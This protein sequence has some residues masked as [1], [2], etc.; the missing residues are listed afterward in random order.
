MSNQNQGFTSTVL[1]L[2]FMFHEYYKANPESE[3]LVM[4]QVARGQP[5][6][7]NQEHLSLM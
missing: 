2:R 1:K 6:V 3:R 4:N 7:V 5:D